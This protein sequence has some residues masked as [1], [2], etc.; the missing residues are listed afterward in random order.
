M[1]ARGT[2]ARDNAHVQSGDECFTVDDLDELCAVVVAAW[3]AGAER[4]WSVPAGTLEWS[5]TQTAD[6]A[7]DCVYAPAFFLASRRQDRYPELGANMM[8]GPNADPARLVESLQI[9]ARLLAGVV[10]NTPPDVRA[11]LFRRPEVMT[12]APRDFPPRAATEL[13]LHAHDVCAGL[14]VPFEPPAALC[15]HLREHTRPWPM[16]TVAWGGLGK[17]DDPWGDLLTASGRA[18][19]PVARD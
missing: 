7:V 4:D 1:H 19:Q 13:V 2:A 3:T 15:R 10:R 18:R 17:T 6:H 14:G 12:A 9:A 5:C 16:W 11:V 8:L